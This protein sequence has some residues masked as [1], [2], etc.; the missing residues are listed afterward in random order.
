LVEEN[1]GYDK[2]RTSEL[3][4]SGVKIIRFRN[5]EVLES[6]GKGKEIILKNTVIN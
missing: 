6:L 1:I 2:N 5:E 4:E 3:K